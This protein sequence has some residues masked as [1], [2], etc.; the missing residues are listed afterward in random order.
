MEEARCYRLRTLEKYALLAAGARDFPLSAFRNRTNPARQAVG[1]GKAMFVFHMMRQRIGDAAFWAALRDIFAERRYQRTNWGH[2]MDAFAEHGGLRRD[3][4]RTFHD[5]WITRPGA[6]QLA[7]DGP[8]VVSVAGRP[9]VEGMLIQKSPRFV[10]I[11]TPIEN[12]MRNSLL[13]RQIDF[14]LIF[15]RCEE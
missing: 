10:T 14:N 1:Y 7:M 9:L 5:Q 3:S 6:L 11:H 4:V 2:F 15:S 12:A 8:R 13:T